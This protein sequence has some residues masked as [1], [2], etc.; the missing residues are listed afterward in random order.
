MTT[1]GVNFSSGH[2]SSAAVAVDGKVVFAIA[3]ERI[4]RQKQDARFPVHAINACLDF[5]GKKPSEI[6]EYVVDW[7]ELSGTWLRNIWL[8]LKGDIRYSLFS[9]VVEYF[10]SLKVRNTARFFERNGFCPASKVV[11]I[12]HHLAHA[13]SVSPYLK[14]EKSLVFVLDGSGPRETTSVYL[15]T[16]DRLELVHR[17]NLPHSLGYF[18]G[19]ITAFCGFKKN[20]DE[21]KV[22]G[23]ASY[24]ESKYNLDH[25]LSFNG[26][27]YRVSKDML[28]ISELVLNGETVKK[29]T[30]EDDV[31]NDTVIKDLARSTQD[32]FERFLV[33]FVDYFMKKYG[34]NSIG[35][36]GGVGL[37]CKAN[38]FLTQKLDIAEFFIQPAATDDGAAI[39][40]AL[41]PFY[42]K[43]TLKRDVFYPYLGLEYDESEILSAIKKYKLPFSVPENTARDAAQELANGRL[44]GWYQGRDE[45]GPRALGN[46]SIVS[47]P[48]DPEM[49]NRVNEVV[50]YRENWRPFA[51]SMLEEHAPE[52]LKH[53]K[54]SPYMIL[55]DYVS[56]AWAEKIPAVVHVDGTLRPQTVN[57][58]MNPAYWN[59]I[60]EFYKIT[61]VPVV[62]NTSFNL[63]GEPNVSSPTD[64][65]RTFFTSGLE[66]LYMGKYKVSKRALGQ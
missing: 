12:D 38:G 50:K 37:N 8:I 60:N 7:P 49:K 11:H 62:M 31:I 41:F 43:G 42:E 2:D 14:A 13:L 21:W 18:Y 34:V 51:P 33:G 65:I 29:R 1:I 16:G 4:T 66:V 22:M 35:L 28:G 5:V 64:A 32:H 6:D 30:N 19:D 3:E 26:K 24:G 54:H 47:D 59:L 25:L 58:E 52:I 55:T 36:A 20:S 63:K 27:D 57:K 39:G 40:A 23:L 45:F 9:A 56:D 46:R 15:K 10:R 48:R 44:L 53:I 61:G 17:V